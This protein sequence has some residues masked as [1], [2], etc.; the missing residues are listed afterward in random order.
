[1]KKDVK[2]VLPM[3]VLIDGRQSGITSIQSKHKGKLYTGVN[4]SI[5]GS[6]RRSVVYTDNTKN[7]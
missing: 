7:N 3:I 2:P 6:Q 5:S 1:V 4:S